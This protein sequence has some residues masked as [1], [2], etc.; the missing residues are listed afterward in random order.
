MSAFKPIHWLLVA[1]FGIV[2]CDGGPESLRTEPWTSDASAR[3]TFAMDTTP[4]RYVLP[5]R[6]LGAGLTLSG[7]PADR[8]GRRTIELAVAGG[9]PEAVFEAD[10][11]MP[12]LGA[13]DARA[14]AAVCATRLT[15]ER[16]PTDTAPSPDE[17]TEITCRLRRAD[18]TY[19]PES[20]IPCE[21]ACWLM[22]LVPE[23]DGFT[24]F[25]VWDPDGKLFASETPPAPYTMT[26]RN[27]VFGEPAPILDEEG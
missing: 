12:A 26:Y 16:Q 27:G 19:E 9:P 23:D 22:E 1:A 25:Y 15:G 2:A 6:G 5:V 8:T 20:V 21:G 11:F 3:P 17:G 13:V 14:E 24:L 7:V 10:W 18:G 4:K